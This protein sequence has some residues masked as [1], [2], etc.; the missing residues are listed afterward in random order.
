MSGIK[1]ITSLAKPSLLERRKVTMI[2][3]KIISMHAEYSTDKSPKPSGN[4]CHKSPKNYSSPK[5]S[6][7][8]YIPTQSPKSLGKLTPHHSSPLNFDWKTTT[9]FN[10]PIKKKEC[11]SVGDCKD[12]PLLKVDSPIEIKSSD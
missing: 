2:L 1:S 3:P 9:E 5:L 8:N 11:D 12:C 4:G 10:S 6:G 7:Y